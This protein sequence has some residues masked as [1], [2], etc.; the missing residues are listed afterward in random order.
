M[1]NMIF[2]R[3]MGLIFL[4]VALLFGALGIA[5][6]Q[7]TG[8]LYSFFVAS[9]ALLLLGIS[10]VIL[11]GKKISLAE[12]NGEHPVSEIFKNRELRDERSKRQMQAL[13]EA[14]KMHL[15]VWIIS[16]FAGMVLGFLMIF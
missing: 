11:P 4:F 1:K 5:V 13:K 10:M 2:G 3:M 8:Y 7:E 12:V 15:A 9:P 16:T 6:L 14:P